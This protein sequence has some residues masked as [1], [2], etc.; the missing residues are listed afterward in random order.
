L[1]FEFP[2]N[3]VFTK[4]DASFHHTQRLNKVQGFQAVDIVAMPLADGP[5]LLLEVKDFRKGISI[6]GRCANYGEYI[7]SVANK[8]L[9]TVSGLFTAHRIGDD[10]LR[11][12][13]GRLLKRNT[14]IQAVFFLEE[15]PLPPSRT[16]NPVYAYINARAQLIGMLSNLGF[17]VEVYSLTN[18]PTTEL[19]TVID[20][21][22]A[23]ATPPPAIPSR[24]K[25][26]K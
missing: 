18:L 5:L 1:V 13:Y 24:P 16:Y 10:P 19:W 15:L 14:P 6:G 26:K 8:V 3:W 25:K 20:R 12:F 7:A 21:Y 4:Y 17:E 9:N 23:P 22:V 2:D 11:R